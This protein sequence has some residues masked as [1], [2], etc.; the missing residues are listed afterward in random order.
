MCG[1]KN[2]DDHTHPAAVEEQLVLLLLLL[3]ILLPHLLLRF[4]QSLAHEDGD[5]GSVVD[6]FATKVGEPQL[7]QKR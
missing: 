3:L 1:I 6:H 2:I 5:Q 4:Q 7:R